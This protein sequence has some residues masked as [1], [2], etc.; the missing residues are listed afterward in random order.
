MPRRRRGALAQRN[1]ISRLPGLLSLIRHIRAVPVIIPLGLCRITV[2]RHIIIPSRLCAR[3][4]SS[5][6]PYTHTNPVYT[7]SMY[8]YNVEDY[9]SIRVATT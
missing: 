6:T 7:R 9:S 2:L 3:R 5:S 8:M 1:A 4:M